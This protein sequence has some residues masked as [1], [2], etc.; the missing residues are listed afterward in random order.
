MK[1]LG[2]AVLALAL[3]ASAATAHPLLK[4]ASPAPNAALSSSPTEIRITFSEGLIAAFSGIS[5]KDASGRPVALGPSR[6]GPG[7]AKQLAA[8]VKA[9]LGAGTYVV[10]WHAVGDD[11]HHVAGHYSFQVK[12]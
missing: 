10:S 7:N 4:T 3:A 6:I 1:R 8:P 5:L 12:P 9:Q 2:P 11:T